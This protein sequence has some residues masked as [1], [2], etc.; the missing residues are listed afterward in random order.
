MPQSAVRQ[1][2]PDGPAQDR[3]D[4]R[5]TTAPSIIE[6]LTN[7]KGKL[8]QAIWRAGLYYEDSHR[9]TDPVDRLVAIGFE[10]LFPNSDQG[11]LDSG[12]A[13]RRR[14]LWDKAR[15]SANKSFPT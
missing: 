7:P 12:S 8:R 13:T 14:S 11:E 4:H 5:Q 3:T 15:K 9:K 10:A 6:A 1:A 2:R